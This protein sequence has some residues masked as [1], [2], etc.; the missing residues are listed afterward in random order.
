[1]NQL[2]GLSEDLLEFEKVADALHLPPACRDIY[3]GQGRTAPSK[4]M[5][6]KSHQQPRNLTMFVDHDQR[7]S[8]SRAREATLLHFHRWEEPRSC[9]AVRSNILNIDIRPIS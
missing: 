7:S 2:D 3:D 4:P 5:H 6:N 8:C 9:I 1:M